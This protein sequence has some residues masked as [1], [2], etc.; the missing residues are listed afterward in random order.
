MDETGSPRVI[1]GVTGSLASLNALRRALAEARS[2]NAVLQVVHVSRFVGGDPVM[3]EA[4]G[5]PGTAPP[6]G[7]IGTWLDEALGGPPA[8][9][10]LR[11]TLVEG[12]PPGRTLVSLVRAETD[13]LV[14][15]RSRRRLGLFWPGSV[16]EY[17]VRRAA[18]PVLVVPAPELA[19][20]L[21]EGTRLRR[22]IDRAL[23]AELRAAHDSQGE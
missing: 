10:A 12:T 21:G 20:E 1:V 5:E 2:R 3:P 17:C 11:Q 18:C 13:L 14:V 23:A 6:L 7:D 4:L 15:G 9:V 19:R 16:A 8:G 22:Q